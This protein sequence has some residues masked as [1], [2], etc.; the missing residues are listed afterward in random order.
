MRSFNESPTA[1]NIR[2]G[3]GLNY[4]L[5]RTFDQMVDVVLEHN[6]T[7]RHRLFEYPFRADTSQALIDKAEHVVR[8]ILKLAEGP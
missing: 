3:L 1:K 8:R 4:K 5:P 7:P 2:A 6:G